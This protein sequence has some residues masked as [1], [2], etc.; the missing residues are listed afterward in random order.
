MSNGLLKDDEGVPEGAREKFIRNDPS[1][2]LHLRRKIPVAVLGAASVLGQTLILLLDTHPWFDLVALVDEASTPGEKYD[3]IVQWQLREKIPQRIAAMDMS[4]MDASIPAKIVFS[5]MKGSKAKDIETAYAGSGLAVINCDGV[6][7]KNPQVPTVIAEV[8]PLYLQLVQEQGFPIGG[9]ILTTPS[10]A[11]RALAIALRPLQLEFGI[12]TCSVVLGHPLASL[13]FEKELQFLFGTVNQ[14]SIT[15]YNFSMQ[16]TVTKNSLAQ[17]ALA[18][19]SLQFKENPDFQDIKQ[20][21]SNFSPLA[22]ETKLPSAPTQPISI[23][24]E[25]HSLPQSLRVAVG[26]LRLSSTTDCTF[27]LAWDNSDYNAARGAIMNA[28]LLVHRGYIFW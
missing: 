20:A 26:S 15:P 13:D 12:R 2:S 23:F 19:V 10:C 3:D 21:L 17:G 1:N 28:E 16:V 25:S 8:N 9:L 14:A 4:S 11:T 18:E 6:H 5:A 24:E 22:E 27:T 7:T